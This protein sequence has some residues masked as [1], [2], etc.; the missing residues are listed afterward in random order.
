MDAT[1]LPTLLLGGDPTG[2]AEETL[3]GWEAALKLPAVAGLVLGRS[4][5]Y[6]A[7][8]DVAQA[9]DDAVSLLR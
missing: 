9:V 5:L 4:M 3:A 2:P 8:G 7:G 1:T 6:P